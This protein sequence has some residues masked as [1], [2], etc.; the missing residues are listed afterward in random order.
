MGAWVGTSVINIS[1]DVDANGRSF[2]ELVTLSSLS[3][4]SFFTQ[5]ILRIL[6]DYHSGQLWRW[7]AHV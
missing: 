3:S 4:V 6:T 1:L 7:N 5:I 2:W